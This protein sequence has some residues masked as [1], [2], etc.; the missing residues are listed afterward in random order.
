MALGDW[1]QFSDVSGG[2]VYLRVQVPQ[3]PQ[4]RGLAETSPGVKEELNLPS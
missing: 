3:V 1:V 2:G 4:G